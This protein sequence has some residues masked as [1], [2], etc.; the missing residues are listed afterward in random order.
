MSVN[1]P[2]LLYEGF[3][4]K[5]K[6][7]LKIMWVTYWFRLQNATLFFYTKKN[8]RASHLRGHYYI[9]TVQS[10]REVHKTGRKHFMFE[11]V[12]TNGKRKMLA[13]DTAA[14]RKEWVT[15][16]WQ[17]MH[18]SGSGMLDS[19]DT[20]LNTCEQQENLNSRTFVCSDRD[21]MMEQLPAQPLSPPTHSNH[22]YTEATSTICPP[23]EQ[24]CEETTSENILLPSDDHILSDH[25]ISY[26]QW[27]SE[28]SRAEETHDGVYDVLPRRNIQ[29]Y[30]DPSTE[31]LE[32]VY[33]TPMS[34][35]TSLELND[36]TD[37]I[38]D[39]PSCLLRKTC[40]LTIDELPEEGIYNN[41]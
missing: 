25:S 6:D 24:D 12:M 18:L 27:S 41:I 39:V 29:E 34:Y 2:R 5:R 31:M 10:V 35:R 38:Y 1:E 36:P 40:N 21:S 11:I 32:D 23:E 20:H 15:H 4:Q 37:S 8:G 30:D 26:P 7:R 28:M 22:T 16:L 13:A 3:L 17:A 9:Y 19:R 33:D 14:L